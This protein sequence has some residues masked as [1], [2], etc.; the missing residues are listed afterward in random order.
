MKVKGCEPMINM[1]EGS[2]G[3]KKPFGVILYYAN[4]VSKRYTDLGLAL[5]AN[6]T[7]KQRKYVQNLKTQIETSNT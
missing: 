6:L 4:G 2:I 1:Y 3:Y 7:I 5:C